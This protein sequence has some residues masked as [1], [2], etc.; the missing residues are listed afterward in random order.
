MLCGDVESNPGPPSSYQEIEAFLGLNQN[1][2]EELI[3]HAR[4][5]LLALINITPP[6]IG[7]YPSK[8]WLLNSNKPSPPH[9]STG[10]GHPSHNPITLE[11]Q[12]LPTRHPLPSST[13]IQHYSITSKTDPEKPSSKTDPEKT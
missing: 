2:A 7:D 8:I 6:G 13:T 1:Q 5:K 4:S 3:A 12:T 11:E 10:P 9:L